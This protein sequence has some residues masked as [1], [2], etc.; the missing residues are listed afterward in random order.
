MIG[1]LLLRGLIAGLI[2]GMLGFGFAK[3]IG[4]PQVNLAIAFEAKA[5]AARGDAPEPVL[6]SRDVQSSWGLLTGVLV[7]GSAL[8]GLFALVFAAS[9]GRLGSDDPRVFAV[10]IALAGFLFVS[11]LPALKYPPN[12]PSVGQPDTIG[13]RTAYFFL[14]LA[15]SLAAAALGVS[16]SRRLKDKFGRWYGLLAATGTVIVV[17]FVLCQLLPDINEVPHDFSAVVLWRFRIAG[18]GLQIVLWLGIGLVFGELVQRYFAQIG[19]R[20]SLAPHR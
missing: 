16:V 7:Y 1:A 4:E 18:L 9:W 8:G 19:N 20:P 15:G 13:I 10:L 14:M 11:L 3:T 6:V 17:A 12:P 2:A 5:D